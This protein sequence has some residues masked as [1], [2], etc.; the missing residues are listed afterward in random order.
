MIVSHLYNIQEPELCD[1]DAEEDDDMSV[2]APE[3]IEI[4]LIDIAKI[5]TEV[6]CTTVPTYMLNYVKIP[7][8]GKDGR[9]LF[10]SPLLK[11]IIEDDFE[12]YVQIM[13]AGMSL[14][15]RPI[16]LDAL[17]PLIE[18]DRPAMLDEC[19]RRTGLGVEFKKEELDVN[20]GSQD[21]EADSPDT[22]L[23]Q[24]L[25]L[26]VHGKKRK[27]LA[28]QNDPH[29]H[30]TSTTSELPLLWT[31]AKSGAIGIVRYLASDQPLAAYKYYASTR[32]TTRAKQIRKISDL[33]AVLP[34]KLGWTMS[35]LNE[36]VATAAI[37][38]G[39]A[40]VLEALCTMRG[41]DFESTLHLKCVLS[42][43]HCDLY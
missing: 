6:H 32:S 43:L 34:E 26:N 14:P 31:A 41:K 28:T 1:D 18:Y 27:D 21:S 23:K 9:A 30:A 29:A 42:L 25:G 13:D 7:Y 19:I 38:G 2:G 33:A 4:D 24:Y 3:D 36:S 35:K 39:H 10:V 22:N 16:L 17:L 8:V 40:D 12:A 20:S 37:V 5:P 15:D 11:A